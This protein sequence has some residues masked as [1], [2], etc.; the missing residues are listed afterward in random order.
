MCF[1]PFMKFKEGVL[2]NVHTGVY[3]RDG[4]NDLNRDHTGVI[5]VAIHSAGEDKEQCKDVVLEKES[6]S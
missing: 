4:R 3:M 1:I 2:N 5:A 6:H